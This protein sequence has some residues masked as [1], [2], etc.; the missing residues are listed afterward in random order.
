M[1]LANKTAFIT[2]AGSG[3]GRAIAERFAAEGAT[4]VGADVDYDS[5]KE[6]VDSIGGEAVAFEL[7][8]RD[9]EAVRA[10]ID[11]TA[12]EYGLDILVNNAGLMHNA[13]PMERLDHEELNRLIDVNINGVWN[14]C[15]AALPHFKNQGSGS[16]VNTAS[17]AGIIGSPNYAGYSLTKGAV[18]NVTRA[19]AAEAGPEGV[20]VNA[21]CPG[22]TET[23][24]PKGNLSAEEWKDVASRMAEE[25]PLGRL[26]QPEDVANA[27]LF[28][29]SDE[30]DWITGEALVIDGGYSCA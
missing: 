1:R 5:V 12:D 26:G 4:I 25:Y 17:L 10:A 16:I 18:V 29:A 2:G 30:A 28:L 27:V 8:V 22:I 15:A 11:A 9:F 14:G 7:D 24:M 3:L 21:V 20:R 19:I 6:T 23:S 13:T